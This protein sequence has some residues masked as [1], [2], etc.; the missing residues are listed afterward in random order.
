MWDKDLSY[1]KNNNLNLTTNAFRTFLKMFFMANK[2]S[3][4]LYD[5]KFFQYYN[6]NQLKSH[7]VSEKEWK[8]T[9]NFRSP[10]SF[11][12]AKWLQTKTT[13]IK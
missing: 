5:K 6:D 9:K 12:S 13:N 11:L 10:I 3:W 1:K 8:N 7:I 4:K 2:K